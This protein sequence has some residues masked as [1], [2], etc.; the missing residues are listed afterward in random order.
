M[1]R[2]AIVGAGVGGLA[3][4]V[5]LAALGHEVEIFEGS[6]FVGGKC[7]TETINGYSFDLG[8]SLFTL[9]AVYRDL[10][11][12]TGAP[13][14]EEVELLAL[15]PAFEYRFSDGTQFQYSG[16]RG[17]LME[18]ISA[19]FGQKASQEWQRLLD[20]GSEMWGVARD[21]FIQSPI[22]PLGSICRSRAPI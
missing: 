22:A 10:F 5:K 3:A 9:P 13:L 11:L 12:K 20:R 14:E 4:A 19:A 1:S 21:P 18:S 2:I 7:R 8:P 6:N 16:T 17:A 15:D